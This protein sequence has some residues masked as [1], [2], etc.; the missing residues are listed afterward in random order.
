MLKALPSQFTQVVS[1][2][3]RP[4]HPKKPCEVGKGGVII[5]IWL[6]SKLRFREIKSIAPALLDRK[7]APVFVSKPRVL[8]KASTPWCV[9]RIWP[10]ESV[11][12]WG[13]RRA[14]RKELNEEGGREWFPWVSSY[15]YLSFKMVD[16]MFTTCW[17]SKPPGKKESQGPCLPPPPFPLPFPGED[18]PRSGKGRLSSPNASVWLGLSRESLTPILRPGLPASS[19]CADLRPGPCPQAPEA[20]LEEGACRAP[21][22][23]AWALGCPLWTDGRSWSAALSWQQ[24]WA[25]WISQ[26]E[27]LLRS[28]REDR[29]ALGDGVSQWGGGRPLGPDQ[30]TQSQDFGSHPE[31]TSNSAISHPRAQG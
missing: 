1:A 8:S 20:R 21:R 22:Q 25:E 28:R 9:R 15:S 10:R 27:W 24:L 26:G 17:P 7:W 5:P 30:G 29:Q 6:M 4:P 31:P 3:T 13:G 2:N 16:L 11:S 12:G 18:L 14:E 23:E 19:C